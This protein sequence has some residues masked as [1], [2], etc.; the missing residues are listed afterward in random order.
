MTTDKDNELRTETNR[1]ILS[2]VVDYTFITNP[3][4]YEEL[5][6]AYQNKYG[7]RKD[8]NM[9][10]NKIKPIDEMKEFLEHLY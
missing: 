5:I 6:T 3:Q 9:L 2:H 4:K 10:L 1:Y 7:D 8:F